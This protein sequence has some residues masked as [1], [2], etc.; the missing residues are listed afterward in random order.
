MSAPG[1]RRAALP[2]AAVILVLALASTASGPGLALGLVLAAAIV[3]MSL[4]RHGTRGR[5]V[6][7]LL[8]GLVA[9]GLGLGALG[10]LGFTIA[11]AVQIGRGHDNGFG[12]LVVIFGIP[13]AVGLGLA[14][15][16][17]TSLALGGRRR[18]ERR[19]D[20]LTWREP[21]AFP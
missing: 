8:L 18:R 21:P 7:Q 4:T 16:W 14:A 17:T 20:G 19:A 11:V 9:L 1:V 3:G 13:L 5:L 12:G 15:L 2:A 6:V 10:V